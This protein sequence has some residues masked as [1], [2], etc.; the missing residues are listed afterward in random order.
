MTP[1]RFPEFK[2]SPEPFLEAVRELDVHPAA[3]S[4]IGDEPVDMAGAKA[5][6]IRAIGLP[7]GFFSETELRNSGADVIIGSL[8]ELSNALH[9]LTPQGS[10]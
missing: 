3:C 1:E 4:A 8:S 7:Q 10:N 5:A 2:P 6:N 9:D